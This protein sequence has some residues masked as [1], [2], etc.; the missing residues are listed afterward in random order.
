MKIIPILCAAALALASVPAV[1]AEE[2]Q[3][4]RI[5]QRIIVMCV[6]K[7]PVDCNPRDAVDSIFCS[8]DVTYARCPQW[9]GRKDW[10]PIQE[11]A[12]YRDRGFGRIVV[13]ILVK[14]IDFDAF[15]PH[16]ETALLKMR[17]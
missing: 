16:R 2:H 4:V 3:P 15:R 6:S 17:Q 8:D 12:Q 1:Q 5:Q 14:D 13:V 11:S 9:G 10:A 7:L